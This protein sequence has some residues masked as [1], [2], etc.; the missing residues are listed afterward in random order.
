MRRLIF[1]SRYDFA[2][3]KS[4]AYQSFP[5]SVARMQRAVASVYWA[6]SDQ[7]RTAKQSRAYGAFQL[8]SLV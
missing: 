3:A 1:G 7:V 4:A 8:R 6:F 2:I 5:M